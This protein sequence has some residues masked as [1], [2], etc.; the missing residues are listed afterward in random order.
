M[1]SMLSLSAFGSG[2]QWVIELDQIAKQIIKKINEAGYSAYFVGGCVRDYLLGEPYQDIDIATAALP[3]VL[4]ALFDTAIPTGLPYGTVTVRVAGQNFE[5]TTFRRDYAYTDGRRPNLVSF[6]ERIEEDLSR[7]D[8]TINAMALS[9]SEQ[10]IDPYGGLADL[11]AKLIRTVGVAAERFAEDKLRKLRAV[12]FAA[13][14]N[15]RLDDDLRVA[16]QTDPNLAGV[17]VERIFNEFN[18]I[19]L[20]EHPAYGLR[21]MA[22]C[23]LLAEISPKLAA[24]I[25]FDQ[26]NPHHKYDLFEHTLRVVSAVPAD[27][28]LRWAALLHDVGKLDTMTIDEAGVGHFYDHQ[29]HSL[30]TA[31]QLLNRLKAPKKLNQAVSGLVKHHMYRPVLTD[32]ALRRWLNKIGSSSVDQ[33]IDLMRADML[34]TGTLDAAF[35]DDLRSKVIELLTRKPVFGRAD[36]AVDGRVLM[37]QFKALREQ[38]KYLKPLFNHLVECCLEQPEKNEQTALLALTESWLSKHTA[39]KRD[40]DGGIV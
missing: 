40:S 21:L 36:L 14:K 9:L 13:Q 6:S 27:L 31:K 32:K 4:L 23:R 3:A 34:A 33:M 20:S 35:A 1:I 28:T 22:D 2:K 30:A 29:S 18:K 19:L 39:L 38:P 10:L 26:K 12:R 16:L 5:V 8:F 24:M 37:A 11:K 17:S 7:R 15:F 25:G